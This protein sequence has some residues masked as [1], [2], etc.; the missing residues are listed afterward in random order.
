MKNLV[1]TT[2]I[3]LQIVLINAF[4]SNSTNVSLTADDDPINPIP[5]PVVVPLVFNNDT[6]NCASFSCVGQF[7]PDLDEGECASIV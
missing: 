3:T 4:E 1:I 6:T 5:I 7:D 2:I